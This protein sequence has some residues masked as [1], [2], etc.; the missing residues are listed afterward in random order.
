[1]GP[2]KLETSNKRQGWNLFCGNYFFIFYF[3]YK[4]DKD[5]IFRNGPYF[6]G[7]QGLYLNR[8]SLDF[9]PNLDIPSVV[10]VWVKLPHL[11]FHLWNHDAYKA[12]RNALGKYMDAVEPKSNFSYTHMC[13]EVDLEE[14]LPFEIKLNLNKRVHV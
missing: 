10:P 5:L 3:E 11:P 4:E 7:P 6:M 13:V 14:C 12:I 9:D 2:T 1:M 8:W